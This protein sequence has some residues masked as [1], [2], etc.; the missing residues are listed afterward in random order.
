MGVQRRSGS[1]FTANDTG[2]A[3]P[4]RPT[5]SAKRGTTS[6]PSR[7][8]FQSHV[9]S[10]MNDPSPYESAAARPHLYVRE[11]RF[12]PRGYGTCPRYQG[13]GAHLGLSLGGP[14]SI[15]RALH[16]LTWRRTMEVPDAAIT[17]FARR[18]PLQP[19]EAVW[20]F[21]TRTLLAGS[22]FCAGRTDAFS[23]NL[24]MMV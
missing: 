20:I 15:S 24:V 7:L 13:L 1:E 3:L 14:V 11:W 21:H 8:L 16:P 22:C 4:M 17:S 5:L 18:L 10:Y 23:V 12:L 6:C 19:W 2:T 9:C